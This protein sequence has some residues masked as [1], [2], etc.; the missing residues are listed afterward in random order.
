MTANAMKEDREQCFAAGMDDFV[1]KPI[2][3]E[4]LVTALNRCQARPVPGA[5]ESAVQGA[6]PLS[7]LPSTGTPEIPGG[8]ASLAGP[9]GEGTLPPEA[10]P[11]VLDLVALERLRGTLGAQAD[12]ILPALIEEFIADAPGLIAEARRSRDKGQPT[13]LRRAAHTLKSSSATFGAVALSALARELE[14]KAR[15][16]ALENVDELLIQVDRAYLEAR[17]ALEGLPKE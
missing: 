9:G 13:D 12:A 14:Y 8:P 1:L 3:F 16:G 11:P 17:V 2:R 5:G 15:D 10:A 4:E 7:P 6:Q